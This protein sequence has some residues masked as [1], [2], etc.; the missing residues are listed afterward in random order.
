MKSLYVTLATLA[1]SASAIAQES[2]E[3]PLSPEEL[4]QQRIAEVQQRMVELDEQ[5]LA[6]LERHIEALERF[7]DIVRERP[8]GE[9]RASQ[10]EARLVENKERLEARIADGEAEQVAE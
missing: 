1:L 2:E 5:F 3:T 9:A 10:L 4:Q 6:S 7:I 8:G